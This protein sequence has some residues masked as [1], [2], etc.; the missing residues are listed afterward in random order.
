MRMIFV[1]LIIWL[2]C[3]YTAIDSAIWKREV[4]FGQFLFPH[5]ATFP[6]DG[7][8]SITNDNA[9]PLYDEI[10]YLPEERKLTR[11]DIS[12]HSMRNSNIIDYQN[13]FQSFPYLMQSGMLLNEKQFQQLKRSNFSIISYNKSNSKETIPII[14]QQGGDLLTDY[15]SINNG[16]IEDIP[17]NEEEDFLDSKS[18]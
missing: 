7:W 12:E 5:T 13:G 15:R 10:L 9:A 3:L 11:D 2:N 4:K 8:N 6:N 17:L 18:V 14:A 16:N 1:C